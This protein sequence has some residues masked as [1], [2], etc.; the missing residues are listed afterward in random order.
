MIKEL[1]YVVERLSAYD[2]A[3]H[4]E[5]Y[6][7]CTTSITYVFALENCEIAQHHGLFTSYIIF[8]MP[9][10]ENYLLLFLLFRLSTKHINLT[11]YSTGVRTLRVTQK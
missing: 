1:F 3:D 5:M 10:L 11:C 8:S 2:A 4:L 7:N 6:A 9:K